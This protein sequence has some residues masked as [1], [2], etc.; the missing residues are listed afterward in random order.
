MVEAGNAYLKMTRAKEHL[1][2]LQVEIAY[3]IHSKPYT[4][5]RED[6]LE[7]DAHIIHLRLMDVP[8]KISLIA[9]EVF[10]CMRSALD[11]LVWSLASLTTV[12]SG[13][14]FPIL[15]TWDTKTLKR[16]IGYTTGVPDEAICEIKALQP[17]NRGNAFKSH[18]LWRLNEMCNLDKHRRIPANG[19][20]I[21]INFPTFPKAEAVHLQ[22]HISDDQGRVTV[23]LRLKD[24]MTFDPA[25]SFNVNFGGAVSGISENISG[26]AEIHQ[27][28]GDSV[29]P[30]FD[31]FFT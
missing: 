14:Q 26:I 30:R 18:P 29:L 13:T 3:F 31:R 10:Y 21:I 22:T 15:E 23:P 20:E 19:S 1:N 9:G 11:Q 12:P 7:N 5:R 6:D 8:P 27:F 25:I 2:N 28:I 17:Y 4:L 24:K 16:F